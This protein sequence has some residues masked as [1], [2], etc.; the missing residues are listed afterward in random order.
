MLQESKGKSNCYVQQ[1]PEDSEVAIHSFSTEKPERKGN[2]ALRLVNC[3]P[4]DQ[5]GHKAGP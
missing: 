4:L 3:R 1:R 2:C 5:S